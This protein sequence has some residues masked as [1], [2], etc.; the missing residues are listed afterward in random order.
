MQFI[1]EIVGIN[2]RVLPS[3]PLRGSSP[4][5]GAFRAWFYVI[6]LPDKDF[7]ALPLGELREAVRG[8]ITQARHQHISNS[9]TNPNLKAV[10]I[11]AFIIY[12]CL[13]VLEGGL[14]GTS[15]KKFP[16]ST[17]SAP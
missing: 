16:P 5:G 15:F 1:G 17:P 2:R 11:V 3:H 6:R 4:G 14:E 13:K 9:P 10:L 12:I 7:K 8:Q